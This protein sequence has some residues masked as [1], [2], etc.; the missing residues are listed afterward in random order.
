MRG[1]CVIA[2]AAAAMLLAAPVSAL[3]YDHTVDLKE[4]SFSWKIVDKNIQIKLTGD[5][6]GWIGIGFNPTKQMEGANYILGY[7][8][9]G[10]VALTDDY[11]DSA[12][13]HKSDE[14]LGGSSD[15]TLIGGSEKGK[16][17]TIEFSIPLN[18]GDKYDTAL[19]VNGDTVVLLGYGGKRDSFKSKHK[20]RSTIT[21]NLST[22]AQK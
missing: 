13:G 16:T 8:K 20:Y 22:G 4:M 6:T 1:K 7:V 10:E 5:S 12:R 21:V 17:T 14:D 9:D 19:D 15:V 2:A 3:A 18:S 11:G